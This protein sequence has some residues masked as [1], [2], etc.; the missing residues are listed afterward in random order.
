MKGQSSIE[1]LQSAAREVGAARNAM[2]AAMPSSVKR[3]NDPKSRCERT[4]FGGG[5]RKLRP[6]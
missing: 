4:A 1:L 2:T 5:L 6:S 3:E